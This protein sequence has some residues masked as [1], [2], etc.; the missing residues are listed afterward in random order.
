MAFPRRFKLV[1][2]QIESLRPLI[3]SVL[4]GSLTASRLIQS[5]AKP[6]LDDRRLRENRIHC[7][8]HRAV[9]GEPDHLISMVGF[10]RSRPSPFGHYKGLRQDRALAATEH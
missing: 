10:F 7:D 2:G 5:V 8:G 1:F 6:F 4:P 3:S 9:H